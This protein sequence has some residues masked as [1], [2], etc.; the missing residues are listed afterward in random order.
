MLA[1]GIRDKMIHN[2]RRDPWLPLVSIIIVIFN[3]RTELQALLDSIFAIQ[4]PDLE[5]VVIDGGSTDGT[6]ELLQRVSSRLAYW[7]SEP[8]GGIYDAMN[9]GVQ[10][11]RG[12]YVLH[13]NAG[14]RL[15]KLPV[16]RL[17]EAGR[18]SVD[19][20]AFRVSLD[21]S[22]IFIP[23]TGWRL[24]L[25]NTWHHQGTFYRRSTLPSYDT[26]YKIF[27]DFDVNQRLLRSRARVRLYPDVVAA[28]STNG[29]SHSGGSD[30]VYR[31][32]RRNFGPV[33]SLGTWLSFKW[34]GLRKRVKPR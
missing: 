31:I 26:S 8:D 19:V 20:A 15:L 13:L 29:A 27:A 32:V 12:T 17:R 5:V 33:R 23:K 34:R 3:D 4:E 11:A 16:Q 7:V 18:D 28:H 14:D 24:S 10:A 22:S 30:E 25:N 2:L 1:A 21:E 6:A 9:K